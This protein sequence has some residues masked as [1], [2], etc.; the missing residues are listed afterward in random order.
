MF[1]FNSEWNKVSVCVCV[2]WVHFMRMQCN[3]VGKQKTYRNHVIHDVWRL[4]WWLQP[5][6]RQ[7]MQRKNEFS[8]NFFA[9]FFFSLLLYCKH[10][11]SLNRILLL[12]S[13]FIP[14]H[15]DMYAYALVFGAFSLCISAIICFSGADDAVPSDIILCTSLI[16]C[17]R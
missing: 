10:V 12:F 4:R 5:P 9:T 11:F 2:W 16:Q 15:F 7:W 6:N 3:Q 14:Y 1:F 8:H 17:V 13:P